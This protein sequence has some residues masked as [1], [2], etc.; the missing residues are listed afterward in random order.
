MNWVIDKIENGKAVLKNDSNELSVPRIQLPANA[1]E[2]DSLSAEFYF[3]K[4]EK[5]RRDNLAR[6]LLEEIVGKS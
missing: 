4:D 6:A 2:G 5:K 3:T 1:K